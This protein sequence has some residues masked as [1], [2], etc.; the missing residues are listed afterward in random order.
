[1]P[2]RT[3]DNVISG[4]VITIIDISDYKKL[5]E[6]LHHRQHQSAALIPVMAGPAQVQGGNHEEK[7]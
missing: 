7:V 2:Y 4:V 1:M 6:T 3:Q 5:E